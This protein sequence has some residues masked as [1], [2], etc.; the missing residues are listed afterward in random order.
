M[1]PDTKKTILPYQYYVYPGN[2][3]QIVHPQGAKLMLHKSE[4]QRKLN[5]ED[6]PLRPLSSHETIMLE[7]AWA[8]LEEK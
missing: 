2:R 4:I 5:G 6:H 8:L 7:T 1:S 3:V